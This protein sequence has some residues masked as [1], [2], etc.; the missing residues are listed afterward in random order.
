MYPIFIT[1]SFRSG[2]T[3]LRLILISGGQISIPPESRV[4]HFLKEPFFNNNLNNNEIINILFKDKKFREWGITPGQVENILPNLRRAD[5]PGFISSLYKTYAQNSGMNTERWGDKN[6]WYIRIS[7]DIISLFPK[8]KII[9]LIRNPFSIYGSVKR[10]NFFS[11]PE[12][13]IK[14]EFISRY[15]HIAGKYLEYKDSN[16]YYFLTY[17]NLV[18]NT[19][20][21]LEHLCDYIDIEYSEKML[22]FHENEFVKNAIPDNK[23]QFHTH[24]NESIMSNLVNPEAYGI[25]EHE[26]NWIRCELKEEI[27]I[28]N[29]SL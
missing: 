23:K 15:K 20:A 3:L 7:E 11:L 8:S 5:F 6:P 24:A 18:L 14:N 26:I 1:G 21:E 13:N 19:A 29:Y 2:T 9:V 22:D 27:E 17:E 10:T 4:I 16:N 25:S 12:D 28:F